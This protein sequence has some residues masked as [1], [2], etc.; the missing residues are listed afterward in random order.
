MKLALSSREFR[1]ALDVAH[2][3]GRDG[4]VARY[5]ASVKVIH[6]RLTARGHIALEQAGAVECPRCGRSGCHRI[7]TIAGKDVLLMFGEVM[8]T[9][10]GAP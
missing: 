6:D 2:A 8:K 7:E 1:A 4:A 10:C 5:T 3:N 9:D